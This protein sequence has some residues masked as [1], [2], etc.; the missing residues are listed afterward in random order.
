MQTP[1]SNR[2]LAHVWKRAIDRCLTPS[3][4]NS[5]Y[6]LDQKKPLK[7]TYRNTTRSL[8]K[9]SKAAVQANIMFIERKKKAPI[10]ENYEKLSCNQTLLCLKNVFLPISQTWLTCFALLLENL[11]SCWSTLLQ[12][13]GRT[14]PEQTTGNRGNKNL[15]VESQ[16]KQENKRERVA[17]LFVLFF[18][19]N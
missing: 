9:S 1:C 15:N 16:H 8:I 11:S 14:P 7:G 6:T 13:Q 18:F 5:K 4:Q 19:S 10:L 3:S 12:S 17:Q 2:S